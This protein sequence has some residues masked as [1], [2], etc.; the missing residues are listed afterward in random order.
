MSCLLIRRTNDKNLEMIQPLVQEYRTYLIF[1][2]G[3][4]ASRPYLKSNRAEI[5]CKCTRGCPD[6]YS[7]L[8]HSRSNSN[9]IRKLFVIFLTLTSVTLKSRSNP[10]PG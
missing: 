3:R 7:R 9:K 8:E 2:D 5:W 10:K 6:T 1:Q 4:Q